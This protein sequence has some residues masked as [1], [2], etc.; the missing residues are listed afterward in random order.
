MLVSRQGVGKI[1]HLS[2]KILWIQALVL[3]QQ[4][5]IGQ[6]PTLWNYSD[7]GTKPLSKN[8]MM[9]LLNQ[10]GAANP[11]TLESVGQEEY[12]QAAERSYNQQALRKISKA[13]F[14][15]A[16]AWGLESGFRGVE[17]MEIAAP[18]TTEMCMSSQASTQPL[19]TCGYG[20]Q[21]CSCL[22]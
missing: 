5:T 9:A 11:N 21:C 15:M 17:A 19:G 16:A 13:V 7:I 2:G 10:L 18:A 8:R 22:Q 14:R 4:L 6:V 3:E 12:E 1:R 20:L